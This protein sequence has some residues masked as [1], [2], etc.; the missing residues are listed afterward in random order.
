VRRCLD[1]H[2]V[3]ARNTAASAAPDSA[4]RAAEVKAPLRAHANDGRDRALCSGGRWDKLAPTPD[5]VTCVHCMRHLGRYVPLRRLL[6]HQ[7][8]QKLRHTRAA[9]APYAVG[10]G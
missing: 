8:I 7:M 1:D 5:D 2:G 9:G 3:G 4:E 10:K 6:E